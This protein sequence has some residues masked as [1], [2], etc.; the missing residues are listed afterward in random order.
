[1]DLPDEWRPSPS[2]EG[3][4]C[5]CCTCNV[6]PS[7]LQVHLS[8]R[9]HKRWE[10]HT[11]RYLD[12]V[13][14]KRS[15]LLPP[16]M[17]IKDY[18]EFCTLCQV[19][20]EEQHLTS[21]RHKWREQQWEEAQLRPILRAGVVANPVQLT[22]I[23]DAQVAPSGFTFQF[24][25]A[26]PSP[27]SEAPPPDAEQMEVP[28][29][30]HA[31]FYNSPEG[32]RPF[33]YVIDSRGVPDPDAESTWEKPPVLPSGWRCRFSGA[34]NKFWFFQ[35]ADTGSFLGGETWDEPGAA[36]DPPESPPAIGP[37]VTVSAPLPESTSGTAPMPHH[38][39]M[40]SDGPNRAAC[41]REQSRPAGE[42]HMS[43]LFGRRGLHIV[44][45]NFAGRGTR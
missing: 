32:A 3:W 23:Q 33:Y 18:C 12:L 29:G 19:R 7:D 31:S 9:R 17:E 5:P 15:G 13:E 30:W 6:S 44:T 22:P 37:P 16:W 25:S 1:M 45:P 24:S 11:K 2:R 41:D 8:T 39:A 36:P 26:S 38:T 43:T 40:P 21:T 14:R 10:E 42:T 4:W 27:P 35:V 28:L 34:H 20:A